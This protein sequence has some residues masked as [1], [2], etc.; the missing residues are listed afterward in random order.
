MARQALVADDSTR[1]LK[2]V[3]L[4][5]RSNGPTLAY[6]LSNGYA[7]GTIVGVLRGSPGAWSALAPELLIPRPTPT[8]TLAA[9]LS[10][11]SSPVVGL[12]LETTANNGAISNGVQLYGFYP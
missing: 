7:L 8:G 10:T 12:V 2:A 9:A 4:L 5:P 1:V 6:T 3:T 11:P